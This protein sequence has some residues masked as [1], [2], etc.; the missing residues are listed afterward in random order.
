MLLE[1][2]VLKWKRMLVFLTTFFEG[3][4][5]WNSL[6]F[7][8]L[9]LI[10]LG[11]TDNVSKVILVHWVE[12][13]CFGQP[14]AVESHK[15]LNGMFG[16]LLSIQHY[17][18]SKC[19][20]HREMFLR[21]DANVNKNN[22]EAMQTSQKNLRSFALLRSYANCMEES[23]KS[24]AGCQV[25]STIPN[26]EFRLVC[27]S[28]IVFWLGSYYHLQGF[29]CWRLDV[30]GNAST[31]ASICMHASTLHWSII[32]CKVTVSEMLSYP[33]VLAAVAVAK[34]WLLLLR[35]RGGEM[36]VLGKAT[37]VV[38]QLCDGLDVWTRWPVDTSTF[39]CVNPS[40]R[41][42]VDMSTS[43]LVDATR[44]HVDV[45]WRRQKMVSNKWFPLPPCHR[46]MGTIAFG[47]SLL[48]IADSL[49]YNYRHSIKHLLQNWL[50]N[51]IRSF[52]RWFIRSF[53]RSVGRSVGRLGLRSFIC[54][55]IGSF[56]R[57]FVRLL[58][59]SFVTVIWVQ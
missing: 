43:R 17:C 18:K 27:S 51:K 36:P 39:W 48:N 9:E 16:V 7:I 15:G 19:E 24:W 6:E 40:I 23:Y 35:R 22:W 14:A 56:A 3:R 34:K 20:C 4:V 10:L 28:L 57:S 41:W 30:N 59:W 5:H 21:S 42:R 26:I 52:I 54:V 2:S 12:V 58:F 13:L 55:L 37:A 33:F 47:Q 29:H 38:R 1:I 53:V 25:C 49:M 44:Q 31:F 32:P 11:S 46:A 8:K 45:S 50:S